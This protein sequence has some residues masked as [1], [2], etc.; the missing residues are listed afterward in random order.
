MRFISLFLISIAYLASLYSY[1]GLVLK[2]RTNF[3]FAYQTSI[4]SGTLAPGKF[5]N[6]SPTPKTLSIRQNKNEKDINIKKITSHF[7]TK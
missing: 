1:A 3:P 5:I 2:N 6:F 7:K 4:S